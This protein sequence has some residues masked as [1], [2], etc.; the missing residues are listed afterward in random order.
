MNEQPGFVRTLVL[1]AVRR[2]ISDAVRSGSLVSASDCA[3]EILHTYPACRLDHQ[4]V[5]DEV[6]LA[7]AKA[8]VPV[9]AGKPSRARSSTAV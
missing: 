4:T 3:A 1:K 5:A 9:E 8:G 6:I 7:A 2:Y